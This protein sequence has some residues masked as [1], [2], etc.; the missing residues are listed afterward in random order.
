MPKKPTQTVELTNDPA[1]DEVQLDLDGASDSSP[2]PVQENVAAQPAANELEQAKT[3]ITAEAR[4][5]LSNVEDI[6]RTLAIGETLLV[7]GKLRRQPLKMSLA[8]WVTGE[9]ILI[10]PSLAALAAGQIIKEELLL[11]RYL[12]LGK[13]YGFETTALKVLLDPPLLI[14]NW[15][16]EVEVAAVSKEVRYMAKMP[17]VILF[18]N[19]G[20][21]QILGSANATMLEMSCGGCRIKTLWQNDLMESYVPGSLVRV[22]TQLGDADSPIKMNCVVRNLARQGN[23]AVLG[24]QLNQDDELLKSQINTALNMQLI[25]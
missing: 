13:V 11:V 19:E 18:L 6:E 15:P 5:S 20:Q 2:A 24:L 14:V 1:G 4:K 21:E 10:A 22:E 23:F 12:L 7:Q 9:S 17:V 25:R 16:A 8:G 3:R